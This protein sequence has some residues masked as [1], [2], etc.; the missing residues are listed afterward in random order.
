MKIIALFLIAISTFFVGH[1]QENPGARQWKTMG[2]TP[3][4]DTTGQGDNTGRVLTY[5]YATIVNIL[6]ADTVFIYPNAYQTVYRDTLNSTVA[7]SSSI[8]FAANPWSSGRIGDHVTF[9]I[10]GPSGGVTTFY[11]TAP[12]AQVVSAGRVVLGA[13]GAATVDFIFNGK[14]YVEDSRQIH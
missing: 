11:N 2:A 1:A 4:F 8:S 14:V 9:I 7:D 5:K 12:I 13:G 6:P 3:R 10:Q